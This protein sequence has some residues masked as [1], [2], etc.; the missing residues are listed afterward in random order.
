MVSIHGRIDW[1]PAISTVWTER[2]HA[3]LR[4]HPFRYL[5]DE[6][7]AILVQRYYIPYITYKVEF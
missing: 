1:C 7:A 4:H 6:N 2:S 5:L 3:R